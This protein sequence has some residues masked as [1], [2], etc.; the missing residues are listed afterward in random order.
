VAPSPQFP[1]LGK[2]SS[3]CIFHT[4]R[5]KTKREEREVAITAVLADEKVGMKPFFTGGK[6]SVDLSYFCIL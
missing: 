1:L 5:R 6:K 2:R 4:G 3:A